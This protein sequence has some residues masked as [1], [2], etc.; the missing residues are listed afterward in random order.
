MNIAKALAVS[1][2]AGMLMGSV[3]ACGGGNA[4]GSGATDPR[5]RSGK[6]SCSGGGGAA[7]AS[8]GKSSCSVARRPA[9]ARRRGSGS[10]STE[11]S[12]EDAGSCASAIRRRPFKDGHGLPRAGT[13]FPTSASESASAG[14]TSRR[15]LARATRHGLVRDRQRELLRRGRHPA[16]EPRGAPRGLPGRPSRRLAVHRRRGPLDTDYLTRLRA[17]VRRVDAP[18]CSDHL[19]WT[20]FGRRRRARSAAPAVH[21]GDARPRRRAREARAGQLGVP[22]ALE[23]ASSYMEYRESTMPEHAFLAE[24]AERADCGLLLDVNNVYVSAYNHGFDA[25]RVHRRHPGRPGR[26]DAPRRARRQGARTCSTRT[27]TT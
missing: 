19:C 25:E 5:G 2:V 7:P 8:S 18:W 13:P 3:V 26:A 21:A 4:G 20:G 11:P 12:G 10:R 23:N 16:R 17:L 22:F 9:A 15:V 1:A 24:L 14:L 27:A 6:S